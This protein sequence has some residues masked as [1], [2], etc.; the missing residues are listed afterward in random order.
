MNNYIESL[1]IGENVFVLTEDSTLECLIHFAAPF[2]GSVSV[3]I[4]KGTCFALHGPMRDDAFYMDLE[5][6]EPILCKSIEAKVQDKYPKLLSR[7][8]RVLFIITKE[9][10][11]TLPL[12]F[13][14]GSRERALEILQ[15]I[16]KRNEEDYRKF[17]EESNKLYASKNK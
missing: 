4:P 14:T 9:E 3:V 10:L 16:I 12:T 2:T 8:S 17:L 7:F 11:K 15:L 1:N 6:E 5:E 13:K